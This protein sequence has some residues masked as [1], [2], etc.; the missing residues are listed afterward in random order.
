VAEWI[1]L[2]PYSLAEVIFSMIALEDLGVLNTRLMSAVLDL[3]NECEMLG[4]L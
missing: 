4:N 3:I 1:G 2:L